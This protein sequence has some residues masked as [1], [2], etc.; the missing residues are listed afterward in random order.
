MTQWQQDGYAQLVTQKQIAVM[1]RLVPLIQSKQR[2]E[3][4]LT[5]LGWPKTNYLA[6]LAIQVSISSG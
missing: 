1:V 5:N 2:R 6:C 4:K 3:L